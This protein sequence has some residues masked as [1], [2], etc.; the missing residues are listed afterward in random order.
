MVA[1][2]VRVCNVLLFMII[3]VCFFDPAAKINI[4]SC[5]VTTSHYAVRTCAAK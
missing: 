2:R 4:T 3:P 1:K 5:G